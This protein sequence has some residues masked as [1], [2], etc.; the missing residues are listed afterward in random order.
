VRTALRDKVSK[1]RVGTEVEGML[2][3]QDPVEA[4][5]HLLRMRL[6]EVRRSAAQRFKGHFLSPRAKP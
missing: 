2:K 5:R 1:E 6:F 3:G 4:M